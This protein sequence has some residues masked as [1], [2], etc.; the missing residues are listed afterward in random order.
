MSER[1]DMG[2]FLP[3][4][5]V[6]KWLVEKYGARLKVLILRHS[7]K[8]TK[9]FHQHKNTNTTTTLQSMQ[10]D[11][12]NPPLHVRIP[13][14]KEMKKLA[15]Q[16]TLVLFLAITVCSSHAQ[17]N[18]VAN[19]G[20]TDNVSTGTSLADLVEPWLASADG[21]AYTEFVGLQDHG[22]GPGVSLEEGGGFVA[23]MRTGLIFQDVPDKPISWQLSPPRPRST[24]GLERSSMYLG[25]TRSLKLRLRNRLLGICIRIRFSRRETLR[26]S[27][28][29]DIPRVAQPFGSTV[30]LSLQSQNPPLLAFSLQAC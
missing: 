14:T 6:R 7:K 3:Y 27:V 15:F 4:T 23:L 28:F 30:Y 12:L 24:T 17:G 5:G 10:V 20:F 11:L 2:A 25:T 13:E 29:Q 9:G 19:G 26:V 21:V 16:I 1:P 8:S 22:L 18:L